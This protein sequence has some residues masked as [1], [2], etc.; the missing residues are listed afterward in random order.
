MNEHHLELSV[1]REVRADL[2]DKKTV[3]SWV[4]AALERDAQINIVFVGPRKGRQLNVQY[5]GKD[6]ATNVLTFDYE[7]KPVA[8]ADIVLCVP[9][10]EKE[11][12][13][14]GKTFTEH[15]A[16][17]IVHGVLHA[18]GYDHARLAQAKKMEALETKIMLALGFAD[19]YSDPAKAH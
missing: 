3:R 8:V 11:A 1:R 16:H 9:V 17:L 4:V 10:V 13:E 18:H 14:Q 12:L 2:P 5:R 7:H 6:Y 15:L 19:P